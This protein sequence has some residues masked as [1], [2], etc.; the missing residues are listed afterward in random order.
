MLGKTESHFSVGYLTHAHMYYGVGLDFETDYSLW[1]SSHLITGGDLYICSQMN[2]K[3]SLGQCGS[4][5]R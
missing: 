4:R 1:N 5:K 3:A 2:K